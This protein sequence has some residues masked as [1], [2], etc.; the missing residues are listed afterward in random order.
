M[1]AYSINNQ[2]FTCPESWQE[3]TVEQLLKL[4]ILDLKAI[5]IISICTRINERDLLESND[6]VLIEDIEQTLSFLSNP[7]LCNLEIEQPEI[8][9]NGVKVG[10]FSDIGNLSIGQ[11]QD[12]KV[13]INIFSELNQEDLIERL[14]LYTKIVSI[15]IQPIVDQT[16]YDYI[17]ADEYAK[18]LFKHS[19]VEVAGIGG[20][21]IKSFTE[22]RLG[23]LRD[24]QKSAMKQKKTKLG[25]LNS[26]KAWVGKLSFTR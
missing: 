13:L 3:I 15:Y 17:K 18:I 11:Y 5:E 22:L 9:F 4:N 25:F 14:D 24:A 10:R 1:K 26:L 8:V 7:D 16:S 6:L 20:F 23:I 12:L 19:A 21:F 2:Q